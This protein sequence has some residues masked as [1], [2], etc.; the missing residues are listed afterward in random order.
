MK[1]EHQED[2]RLRRITRCKVDNLQEHRASRAA[3]TCR[4]CLTVVQESTHSVLKQILLMRVPLDLPAPRVVLADSFTLTGGE[5]WARSGL[6]AW[7]QR[8]RTRDS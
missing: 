8:A 3:S 7:L 5:V 6:M 2:S 1:Q 4:K